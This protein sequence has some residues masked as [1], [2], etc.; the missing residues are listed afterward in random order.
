MRK[1]LLRKRQRLDGADVLL[2]LD[3]RLVNR[4][5]AYPKFTHEAAGDFND[6]VLECFEQIRRE[7]GL[8][9]AFE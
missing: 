6:V 8:E 9:R 5:A 3:E 7:Y 1:R 4:V 2:E